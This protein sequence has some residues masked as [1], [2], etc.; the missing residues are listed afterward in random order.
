[1]EFITHFGFQ[2]FKKRSDKLI[3]DAI[4]TGNAYPTPSNVGVIDSDLLCFKDVTIEDAWMMGPI[5]YP[6]AFLVL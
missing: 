3:K 2:I 5:P 1:M 4:M 6:P